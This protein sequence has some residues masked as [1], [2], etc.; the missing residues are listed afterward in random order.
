MTQI[1]IHVLHTGSVF[2]SP[3]VPFGGEH[4]ST[5]KASGLLLPKSKRIWIPVSI[6]LIEHP[7]GLILLDTG[8]SRAMSPNGE[9]D[10][11]GQIK[12]MGSRLLYHVNQGVVPVGEAPVEQLAKLGYTPADLDYV[13]LSHLDCDHA[14]GLR[15]VAAG[16]PKQILTSATELAHATTKP[17]FNPMWWEGTGLTTFEWNGTQ[18]PAHHSYDLFGDGSVELINIPGHTLGLCAMKIKNEDGKYVLPFVDGGYAAK[19]WQEMILP[20]IG[21]DRVAQKK[22]LEWIREQSLDPDCVES[23]AT[24]D[25]DVEPHTI[26]L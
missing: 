2:V 11:A 5:L 15:E 8:W 9:L 21:V 6:Y 22:S 3:A 23:I 7:K 13:I 26:T 20:G 12:E 14:V 16:H 24:H 17:R 18:G 10:K 1:K 19:S 25:P 4:C